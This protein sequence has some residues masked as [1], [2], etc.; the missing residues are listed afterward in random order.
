MPVI[1]ELAIMVGSD[2]KIT[3]IEDLKNGTPTIAVRR[4]TTGESYAKQHLPNAKLTP[5]TLDAAC[6]LEVS[7][8]KAEAWIYDQLSIWQHHKSHPDTTKAL[9]ESFQREQWAI[10]IRKGND[11]MRDQVN[12]FLTKFKSEKGFDPLA[13]RYLTKEK[14]LHQEM[15]TPFLFD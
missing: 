9:L 6:A 14:A 5:L 2:S 7:Q 15:G 12:A 1:F 11:T 13:D 8:G 10:A 4:G 3:G